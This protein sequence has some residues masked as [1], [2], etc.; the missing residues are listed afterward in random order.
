MKVTVLCLLL[1][2]VTAYISPAQTNDRV[3]DEQTALIIGRK[4][5]ERTY[6]K[7]H[8]HDEEPLTATLENG[9]WTVGGTFYCPD[10]TG[11]RIVCPKP[12][13]GGVAFAKISSKTGK[14]LKVTHTK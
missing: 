8:I 13:P 5:L 2:L 7:K 11:G 12:S 6:G 10:G 3:P 1:L 9:V 4:A 14:I